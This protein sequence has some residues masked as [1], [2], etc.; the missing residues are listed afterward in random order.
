MAAR[1]AIR[2]ATYDRKL[3]AEERFAEQRERIFDAAIALYGERGYSDTG[4]REVAERAA[5]S[6]QTLYSHFRD[7]AQLRRELFERAVTT[8]LVEFANEAVDTSAADPLGT[9]LTNAFQKIGTHRGLARIVFIESRAPDPENIQLR[10]RIVSFF[11][12][13]LMDALE[14]HYREGRETRRPDELTVIG[15]AGA[16]EGL[17]VH[18][19]VNDALNPLDA[20]AAAR[21]IIACVYSSTIHAADFAKLNT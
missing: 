15:L 5:V 6:R 2:S 20:V 10:E 7:I 21:R 1:R 19:I 14:T 8:T 18:M 13:L 3:S 17:F 12:S 11:V 9:A 16:V 4:M